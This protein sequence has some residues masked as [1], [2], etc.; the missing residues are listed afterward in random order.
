LKE[1]PEKKKK[2]Y[3]CINMKIL[4]RFVCSILIIYLIIYVNM[5]TIDHR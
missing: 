3:I 4:L 2:T 5:E 1:P